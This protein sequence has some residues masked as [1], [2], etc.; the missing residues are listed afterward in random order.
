MVLTD[1]QRKANKKASCKKWY[2]NNKEKM[3]EKNK[4]WYKKWRD[5]N[6]EKIKEYTQS[7]E[8]KKSRRIRIWKKSGVK[9][10]YIDL[11]YE[12]Y[13]NTKDCEL[14]F[15][16]LTEDKKNTSTTRC[17]D[18]DHY[19]GMFRNVVCL[20]CNLKLPKQTNKDLISLQ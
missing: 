14:C 18:H 3:K 16:E 2:E 12:K 6:K 7:P 10:E 15:V 13:I 8:G 19:T 5:N 11:L 20:K 17:L 9:C 4:K 1:E